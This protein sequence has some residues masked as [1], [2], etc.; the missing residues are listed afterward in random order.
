MHIHLSMFK[1]SVVRDNL[2]QFI[3][4]GPVAFVTTK[5]SALVR[6]LDTSLIELLD[7]F[8]MHE[9]M[10]GETFISSDVGRIFCGLEPNICGDLIGSMVSADPKLDNYD[11]YDV[12]SGHAPAG[13]SV[14]NLR[15]WQQFTKTGEFKRY[16]YGKREN[17]KKYG[18]EHPPMY[19]LGNIDV[20]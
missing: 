20:P 19:D 6:L 7:A 15:H 11:R 2:I 17:L 5:Y 4:L 18:Q 12:L 1:A 13:T 10:P 9:F 14:H 8:G 16:D 3:G